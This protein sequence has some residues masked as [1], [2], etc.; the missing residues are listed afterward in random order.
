MP[1]QPTQH[2]PTPPFDSRAACAGVDLFF[3]KELGATSTARALCSCCPLHDACDAWALEHE[4][5]GYWAGRT[6]ANRRRERR[7][8]GITLHRPEASGIRNPK[9]AA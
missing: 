3:S 8:R 9:V 6:A 5:F 1:Y 4:E 2:A 7:A